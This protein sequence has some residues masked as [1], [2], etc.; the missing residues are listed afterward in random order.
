[1]SGREASVDAESPLLV[2]GFSHDRTR[3]FLVGRVFRR[4]VFLSES[5]HSPLGYY[6][7]RPD[8]VLSAPAPAPD[9]KRTRLFSENKSRVSFPPSATKTKL[10]VH[11][12]CRHRKGQLRPFP[13]LSLSLSLSPM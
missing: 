9:A 1:M 5:F 11:R 4:L 3:L 8:Q 2:L 7:T 12:C 10:L 13:S 6:D